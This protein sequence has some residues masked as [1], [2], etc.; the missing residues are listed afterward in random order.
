MI[1]VPTPLREGAPDLSFIESAA[2]MLAPHVTPGKP[3]R[4]GVDDLPGDDRGAARAH[5]RSGFGP[6]AQARDFFVGYSPERIDPG[7]PRVDA[8]DDPEGGLR[9]RRR[10]RWHASDAFYGTIVDH[11]VPVSSPK[12]AE[13]AKLLENT[14]RHVN[15]A[16][17]NELAM[18]AADLDIDVWEAID[19]AVDQAVRVHAVH[20]RARRRRPLPADRPELPVVDG[21]AA[22]GPVLPVRRARQR[23]QRPHARLRRVTGVTRAEP[24]GAGAVARAGPGARP[25]LQAQLRATPGSPPPRPWSSFLVAEGADVSVA[26][27]HVV[28]RSS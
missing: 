20:A 10:V 8:A 18:F 6:D 7:Q 9:H 19:A 15:I 17:V 3:R 24:T 28:E 26:D 27:P 23:H 11:T 1:T 14:F 12:S 4:A 25:G 21:A 16:L 13:L 5:P 22:S 2:R